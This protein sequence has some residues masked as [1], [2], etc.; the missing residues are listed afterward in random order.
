MNDRQQHDDTARAGP[1][2]PD[3]HEVEHRDVHQDSHQDAHKPP[4]GT[5]PDTEQRPLGAIAVTGF[6]TFT[7]LVSWFGMY[8]LNLLRS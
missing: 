6:L 7:I 4:A 8:A 3:E 2:P 5:T 1:P